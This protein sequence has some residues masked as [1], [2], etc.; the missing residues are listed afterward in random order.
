MEP[1][2]EN[3]PPTVH[4]ITVIYPDLFRTSFLLG[5]VG[6]ANHQD[7]LEQVRDVWTNEPPHED[8]GDMNFVGAFQNGC[9]IRINRTYYLS[10][11]FGWDKVSAAYVRLLCDLVRNHYRRNEGAKDALASILADWYRPKVFAA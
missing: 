1:E 10:T 4:R 5:R 8:E 7:I 3:P 9:V 2:K 6:N 11:R